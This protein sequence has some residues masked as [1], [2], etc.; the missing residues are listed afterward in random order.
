MNRLALIA[1][2]TLTGSA[3][4]AGCTA[5]VQS[6]PVY[7]TTTT[8]REPV[9]PMPPPPA[10][11]PRPSRWSALAEGYSAQAG[12]Q[13]VQVQ[14]GQFDRIRVEATRGN[15]VIT[16]VVVEFMDGPNNVQVVEPN[17]RL[18]RGEGYVINLNGRNRAINRIAIYT[19]PQYGGQYSVYGT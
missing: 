10:P 13:F 11:E 6:E 16:K 9:R 19:E 18:P 4:A 3:L 12:R 5:T 2:V 1:A 14:G 8:R 15:P 7:A 17:T